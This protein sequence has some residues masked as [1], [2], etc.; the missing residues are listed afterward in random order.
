MS[1]RLFEALVVFRRGRPF[2]CVF[3]E[4]QKVILAADREEAVR[5]A[6]VGVDAAK[7]YALRVIDH[8]DAIVLDSAPTPITLA[9]LNSDLF[10]YPGEFVIVPNLRRLTDA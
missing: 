3:E 1:R 6:L 5:L 2:G 4:T 8:A 10:T 7:V 9:R